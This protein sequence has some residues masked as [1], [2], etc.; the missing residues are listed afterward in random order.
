LTFN[1]NVTKEENQNTGNITRFNTLVC[2]APNQKCIYIL[3][4]RKESQYGLYKPG[5]FEGNTYIAPYDANGYI[6]E[7]DDKENGNV[8]DFFNLT[9]WVSYSG[10]IGASFPL[11]GWAYIDEATADQDL[12]LLT[13]Y[14]PGIAEV[15]F[16]G[17]YNDESGN[18][19]SS[20]V[21]VPAWGGKLLIAQP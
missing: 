19:I 13:N 6:C 7:K 10:E 16:S 18:P 3:N 15:A 20:P 12:Q 14:D 2:T 21:A 11:T 4:A 1:N 8:D 17:P 9:D 5:P